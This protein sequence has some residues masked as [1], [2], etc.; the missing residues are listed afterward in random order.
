M[1]I[2]RRILY[3]F[4]IPLSL[5]AQEEETVYTNRVTI[6]AI[7]QRGKTIRSGIGFLY[8]EN[9]VVGSYSDVKGSAG[10]R[11]EWDGVSVAANRMIAFSES[12][13]LAVLAADEE[14]PVVTPIGSSTTLALGDK[15]SYWIEREGKPELTR[16]AVH[17]IMDTGKGYDLILVESANYASRSTPMYNTDG[18]IV[19]WLQGKRAIPMETIAGFA[20]RETS[21]IAI[22]EINQAQ[23]PWKFSKPA[24]VPE[25]TELSFSEMKSVTGPAAFPFQ[26]DLPGDWEVKVLSASGKFHVRYERSGVCVE[27]RAIALGEHQ[28]VYNALSEIENVV[29][30][31][32][33]RADLIP[34]S[35]EYL[36]GFRASYEDNDAMNPYSLQVFFTS[37]AQKLYLLSVCYPRKIEEELKPFVEQIFASFRF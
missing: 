8:D 23:P 32:F 12:M 37:S 26:L 33:L 27:V 31:D 18:K 4:L 1:M 5:A 9:T 16:G 28:D 10:V 21:G 6:S 20:E 14:I 13:D 2:L 24:G 35:A 15:I 22:P 36:T 11:V 25:A 17:Q 19:G 3:C 30:T 7:D 34:Y 29:F